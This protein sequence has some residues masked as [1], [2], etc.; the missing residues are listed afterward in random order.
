M[1]TSAGARSSSSG[2]GTSTVFTATFRANSTAELGVA[3]ITDSSGA[4]SQ[5]ILTTDYTVVLDAATG[6]PTVTFN[7]APTA[8]ETVLIY[9][10]N[11]VK[12]EN[13]LDPSGPLYGSSIEAVVDK[14][15]AQVQTLQ[16][17]IKQCL[18]LSQADASLSTIGDGDTREA[19][20]VTFGTNGALTL[21]ARS[22]FADA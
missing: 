11:E 12:Q 20:V 10:K 8:G 13:D 18:R 3:V 15:A 22:N 14:L 16:D 7:S 17:E 1:T 21:E 19:T 5:K 2:D 9:P 4:V 6:A